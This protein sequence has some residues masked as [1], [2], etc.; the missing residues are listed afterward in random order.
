M[1]ETCASCATDPR[2]TRSR[3]VRCT[4]IVGAVILAL[5]SDAAGAVRG[6]ISDMR[7]AHGLAGN[8]RIVLAA[9]DLGDKPEPGSDRPSPSNGNG[10]RGNG[11]GDNNG[12]GNGGDVS[13]GAADAAVGSSTPAVAARPISSVLQCDRTPVIDGQGGGLASHEQVSG[14]PIPERRASAPTRPAG[15][16]AAS[17]EPAPVAP[18]AVP[19]APPAPRAASP[20]PC[21]RP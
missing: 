5:I 12:N 3:T 13:A 20:L 9:R 8:D 2:A 7:S 14:S 10:N 16:P 6:T 21:Y 19:R 17:A 1:A 11:N 4:W 15:R 18:S